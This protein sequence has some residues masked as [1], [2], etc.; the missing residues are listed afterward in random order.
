MKPILVRIELGSV[1]G[2]MPNFTPVVEEYV[3]KAKAA[4]VPVQPA[5]K[6]TDVLEHP[7]AWGA[8]QGS[9]GYVAFL[10][11]TTERDDAVEI[12]SSL[13]VTPRA[14]IGVKVLSPTEVDEFQEQARRI[15]ELRKQRQQDASRG[16]HAA[17]AATAGTPTSP[18]PGTVG[19]AAAPE[20]P[21]ELALSTPE[22]AVKSPLDILNLVR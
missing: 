13:T 17:R 22:G 4:G 16:R 2:P 20:E 7:E 19:S 14:V 15:V 18:L 9:E 11:A 12:L 8:A 6:V 10:G 1:D 21:Y 5:M 3:S